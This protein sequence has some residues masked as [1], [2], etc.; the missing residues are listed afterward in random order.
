MR[1]AVWALGWQPGADVI[2]ALNRDDAT[3]DAIF[4]MRYR[5]PSNPRNGWIGT[6]VTLLVALLGI[7][8]VLYAWQLPPF[9]SAIESTDNAYVR[10]QTTVVSPQTR[11]NAGRVGVS[12]YSSSTRRSSNRQIRI[13]ASSAGRG[14]RGV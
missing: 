1:G 2:R 7:G 11:S 12:G 9:T 3:M 4:M 6:T 5:E 14:E 10:G 13:R 8:V